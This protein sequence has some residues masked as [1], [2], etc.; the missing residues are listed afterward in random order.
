MECQKHKISGRT[1]L[2]AHKFLFMGD[3]F[4]LQPYLV[5]AFLILVD[6]LTL[7]SSK[8][9]TCS[10]CSDAHKDTYTT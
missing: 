4:F 9:Y 1:G 10:S 2:Q 8:D 7:H 3:I 5:S 6:L